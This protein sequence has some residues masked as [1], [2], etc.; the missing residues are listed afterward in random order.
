M[1]AAVLGIDPGMDGG[2][3]ALDSD[4]HPVACLVMPTL[5]LCGRL[6]GAACSS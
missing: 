6:Q 1:T 5:A 3:V 2:L 4:L